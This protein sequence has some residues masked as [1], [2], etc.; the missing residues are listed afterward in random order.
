MLINDALYYNKNDIKIH[1]MYSLKNISY[2]PISSGTYCWVLLPIPRKKRL[3]KTGMKN[4]L[5]YMDG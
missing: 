1:Y 5:K 2:T 4:F 3:M